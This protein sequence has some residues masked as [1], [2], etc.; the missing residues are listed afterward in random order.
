MLIPWRSNIADMSFATCISTMGTETGEPR[1]TAVL[2]AGHSNYSTRWTQLSSCR[3][4]KQTWLTCLL[5]SA[6]VRTAHKRVKQG[7]TVVGAGYRIFSSRWMQLQSC[8]WAYKNK[9]LQW[10]VEPKQ[11]Q[12]VSNVAKKPLLHSDPSTWFSHS[13]PTTAA[14]SATPRVL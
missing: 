14:P 10:S 13:T 12:R 7:R 4:H 11:Q 6:A 9:C 3:W 8:P 2:V 1:A 5:Q